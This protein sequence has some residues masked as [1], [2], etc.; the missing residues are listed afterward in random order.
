[1]K[2]V[3]Y[4]EDNV[5]VNEEKCERVKKSILEG[6]EK[7]RWHKY[8]LRKLRFASEAGREGRE[9][10]SIPKFYLCLIIQDGSKLYIEKKYQQNG[11]YFK[12]CEE[13][14]EEQ[15]R[16]ILNGNVEWMKTDK[17][18]LFRELY[19]EQNQTMARYRI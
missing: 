1:M 13:I 10:E 9:E 8:I 19:I 18:S 11:I 4:R 2:Y 16:N 12:C 3:T 5:T 17:N 14:T 7:V 6:K 15:C